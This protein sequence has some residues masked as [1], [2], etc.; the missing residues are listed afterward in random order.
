MTGGAE[1]GLSR[2]TLEV[3]RKADDEAKQLKDEYISV[4]HYLLAM[5]KHDRECRARSSSSTAGVGY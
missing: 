5:S 1:P 4:E 2:R 3:I